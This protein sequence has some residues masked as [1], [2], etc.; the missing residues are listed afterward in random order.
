MT[1][2]LT[3]AQLREVQ[4]AYADCGFNKSTASVRMGLKRTTFVARLAA[5]DLKFG[6]MTPPEN[7]KSEGAIVPTV[8]DVLG[9]NKLK[10]DL[11][12][13]KKRM[14][15]AEEFA[16]KDQTIREAVFGLS[17]EPAEVPSWSV[18][19]DG[20]MKSETL[21]LMLSDLHVGEKVYKSQMNGA[22]SY[23]VEIAG[24]RVRRYFENVIKLS[25][26]HWS[27]PAPEC[28]YVLFMGDLIT[29]EIHEELA[30]TND[31]QSL[32]SV[33]ACAKFLCAG[34][35]MLRDAFPKT[36]INVV[37]IPGN[38][39]R[40]THKPEMKNYA[41]ESYD[42]LIGWVV[43]SHAKARGWS[44]VSFSAPASGDAL[45]QIYGYNYL[46]THGDR[47]GSRGGSGMGGPAVTASRGFMRVNAEYAKNGILIDKILI[48]HFHSQMELE[49]GFV[50]GSL[51]GPNEYAKA[52]RF[53]PHPAAQWM[54]S[55]HP[56]RGIA[57]RWLVQVG[58]PSEGSMYAS[59]NSN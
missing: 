7:V 42:T 38:H 31:L 15:E 56:R 54:L 8:E 49:N 1:I 4:K 45:L 10:R 51:I 16:L 13:S 2:A 43:E 32:G 24:N 26:K 23:D 28:I 34:L 46:V 37:S 33:Q 12:L 48:G 52:G 41:L 14:K 29:G 58:D 3:D 57:R 36:P 59:R 19:K 17:R 27:G 53:N 35:E 55:I 6:A 20:P 9:V 39:G 18:G 25:T 47:I 11:D 44:N 21:I 50:N 30:K 40:T 22:N 5:A